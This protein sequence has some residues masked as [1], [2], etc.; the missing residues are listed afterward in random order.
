MIKGVIGTLL[1]GLSDNSRTD[2]LH[3]AQRETRRMERMVTNLLDITRLES[4]IRLNR[5]FYYL[6]ELLGN[7]MAQ[8]QPALE[9]HT[10]ESDFPA[11]LPPLWVDGLLVEQLFINLLENSCKHTPENSTIRI[12]ALAEGNM[13]EITVA[14][15]GPGIPEAM[16]ERI[17]QKFVTLDPRK[18][19]RTSGLG[20]AIARAVAESHGGSLAARAGP[21]GGACFTCRLPTAQPELAEP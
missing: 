3:A 7:A 18:E 15:N 16:R 14:D 2:L 21:E 19:N 4:G 1:L 20:L 12:G 10:I 8:L 5:D 6:P 17:F 9:S 11:D 13:L